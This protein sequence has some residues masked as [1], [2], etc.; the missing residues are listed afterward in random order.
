MDIAHNQ[1]CPV[2]G[3]KT[4]TIIEDENDIPYFGKVA[5][6]SMQCKSCG[7]RQSDVEALEKKDPA[8]Y[9]IEVNC[10]KDLDIRVVRSSEGMIK[11]PT[12]RMSLEPGTGAQGFVSNIEGVLLRFKK[13][14]EGQRDDAE[15]PSIKKSAKTLLKKMWKIECGD[16]PCKI[17]V[18]DKTGNSV[19]I[20]PKVKVTKLKK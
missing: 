16:M 17:V 8:R 5:L 10:K 20:S 11:I 4:L 12:L 19:I 9:E 15:D 6:F 7:Y 14:V 1:D 2:C 13:I 3:E 18:E